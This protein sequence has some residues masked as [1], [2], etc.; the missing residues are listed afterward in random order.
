MSN[1]EQ[2]LRG[3]GEPAP[4]PAT[5]DVEALARRLLE[6]LGF[7]LTI[8]ARDTE[9]NIEVDITGPD[10][11]FLLDRKAEALNALQYLLNRI[12]YRGRLG[13]KIHLDSGAYRR[14]REEEIVEIARRTAETV[15]ARGEEALLNPL[16][17]YER[18][19]VHLALS[20]IDGV[21]TRSVGEGALKRIAIFPAAKSS[22]GA[23]HSGS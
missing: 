17:S 11:E 12:I 18:R 19:L 5:A 14:D 7:E 13:K 2:D 9:S 16:N 10:R 23:P 3:G 8:A 15:K 1:G 20:E 4:T 21:G 22:P 6:G